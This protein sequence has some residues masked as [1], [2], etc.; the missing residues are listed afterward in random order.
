M[1][2]IKYLIIL[3]IALCWTQPVLA[4]EGVAF[5]SS[6]TL[7]YVLINNQPVL[8]ISHA[9]QGVSVG[10][11]VR[12]VANRLRN[13]FETGDFRAEE[14]QLNT[15]QQRVGLYYHGQLLVIADAMSAYRKHLT[16]E[17]LATVWKQQLIEAAAVF[18]HPFTVVDQTV[19]LA[20]WYGRE[21]RGRRTACGER[22]DETRYTA[23]HRRL[24]FGTRVRVTN[25]LNNRSV[26]VVVNDRGPW[27]KRRLLD[28]SWAAARAIGLTGVARIKLEV[29]KNT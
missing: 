29:L 1:K 25:L 13:I 20:S 17:A 5:Y 18:I 23:A 9:Y 24:P 3:V 26:V 16:P 6:G 8:E 19:G 7:G 22:F 12:I 2:Q 10:D 4:A 11:R 15:A 28:L 21:F 14:L 27:V